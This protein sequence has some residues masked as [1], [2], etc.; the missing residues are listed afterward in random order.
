MK[1]LFFLLQFLIVSS[2]LLQAQQ[3]TV[4][5][6]ITDAETGIALPFVNIVI[7]S[8]LQGSISDIDG[9]FVLKSTEPIRFIRASYVGYKPDTIEANGSPVINFKLQKSSIQLNEVIILPGENPAHRIIDSAIA[10]RKQN[11]PYQLDAFSYESYS[12]FLVTAE[13]DTLLQTPDYKLDS[14]HLDIKQFF[15]KQHVFLMENMAERK[16]LKPGNDNEILTASRVSGFGDPMLTLLMSQIQSF[17]F[18]KS[19]ITISDKNYV[20]PLSPGSTDKYFFL[21]E[22]TI[23]DGRDTVFVISYRPRRNAHFDALKG[24]LYIHTASW[25]LQCVTAEP[26]AEEPGMSVRIKQNYSRPDSVH[27][28]PSQLHTDILFSSLKIAEYP[29]YGHGVTELKKIKINPALKKSDFAAAK[30]IIEP[31]A[32]LKDSLFWANN[33][34]QPLSQKEINT[35]HLIDSIGRKAHFDRLLDITTTMLSGFIPVGPLA[36]EINSLYRN[37]VVEGG[38]P[39]LGLKTNYRVSKSWSLYGYYGYGLRDNEHKFGGRLD[40]NLKKSKDT[41]MA[42]G[43]K[44][45]TRECGSMSY[46]LNTD[47]ILSLEGLR[48]Y[49]INRMDYFNQYFLDFHSRAGRSWT[50]TSR[51]SRTSFLAPDSVLY[52][53]YTETGFAGTHSFVLSDL[54]VFLVYS[55]GMEFVQSEDYSLPIGGNTSNPV[56]MLDLKQSFPDIAGGNIRRTSAMIK[57]S[58][59]LKSRYIGKFSWMVQGSIVTP[60]V[61]ISLA[62]NAPASFRHFTVSA[63]SSF[64]TMRM[65]EFFS[66]QCVFLFL[67]H[68]FESLLFGNRKFSPSPELVTNI[69][70]GDYKNTSHLSVPDFKTLEKGYFESGLMI[71]KILDAGFY[72]L[73]VGCLYRYGPYRLATPKENITLKLTLNYY[74]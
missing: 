59:S 31:D 28:F 32:K 71:N 42:I 63:P 5:G 64:E 8:S 41:K 67:R 44:Q 25:A 21:L 66:T 13:V 69:A 14:A 53:S 65:N 15:N 3:H 11:D 38:R 48:N 58:Q 7:N 43:F 45:D 62:F 18:Y 20:N 68:S 17:S 9:N 2:V 24:L 73:G 30:V 26:I 72:S 12:K 49:M 60:D 47:G 57:I 22:D 6:R 10:H 50:F 23:Y 54:N 4:S 37:N 27:W 55:K 29:V 19:L 34:P 40:V 33:R 46:D 35:Y 52:G 51:L 74:L 61:P 1:Q 56:I 70:W 36:I 39:G 16:Y